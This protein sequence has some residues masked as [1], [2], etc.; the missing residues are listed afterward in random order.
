MINLH[1]K[2]DKINDFFSPKIV[3]EA[4]GQYIK[5]VKILGKKVPWHNHV[6][7]DESFYIIKGELSM[8]IKGEK[9]FKMKKGDLFIVQKGVSHRVSS[10]NECHIMLIEPKS[11][12]H[13]GEVKSTI[14]KTLED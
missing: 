3:G 5:V 4:N 6:H 9:P 2:I 10:D 1:D 13:T 7:E 11:T 14:T 8:E 12:T